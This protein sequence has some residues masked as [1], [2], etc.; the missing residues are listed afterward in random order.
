MGYGIIPTRYCSTGLWYML[1]LTAVTALRR[2]RKGKDER[3]CGTVQYIHTYK[4][5]F[6]HLLA[7]GK[8]YTLMEYDD[9]GVRM[10]LSDVWSDNLL[11]RG[12]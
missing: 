11:R 4:T 2:E 5:P 12:N 3:K 10:T 1:I 9:L 8:K 7:S 6:D